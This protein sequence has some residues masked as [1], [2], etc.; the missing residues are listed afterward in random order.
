[1]ETNGRGGREFVWANP[2]GG[3][4]R[5]SNEYEFEKYHHSRASENIN[6]AIG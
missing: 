1:M 2:N 3:K 5:E 6:V 4:G